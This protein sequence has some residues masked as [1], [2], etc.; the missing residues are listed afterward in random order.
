[1]NIPTT[2]DY[3]G[4]TGGSI[5]TVVISVLSSYHI[6]VTP[7][8]AAGIALAASAILAYLHQPKGDPKSEQSKPV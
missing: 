8:F 6:V 1:M 3:A 4:I 5:A 2:K 7:E